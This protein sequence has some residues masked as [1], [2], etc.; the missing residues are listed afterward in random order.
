MEVLLRR[1]IIFEDVSETQFWLLRFAKNQ[2][3]NIDFLNYGK[4]NMYLTSGIYVY[5]YIICVH[6]LC[7]VRAITTI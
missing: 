2:K 1:S 4:I 5:I 7:M 6:T 3:N